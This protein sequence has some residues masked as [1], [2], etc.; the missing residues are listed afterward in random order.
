[1]NDLTELIRNRLD[2]LDVPPPDLAL[3][4]RRGHRL[5]GLRAVAAASAVVVA[6]VAVGLLVDRTGGGGADDGSRGVDPIGRL[7]L[8]HGLRA[9]AAP[10]AEIHLG[11]RTFPAERLEFLDTDATATSAGVLFYD[12]GVPHLLT[13]SGEITDLEPDAS[14]T[15]VRTTSK[16]DSVG[17]VV[18]YGA[19]L[20]GQLEVRVRDLASGELLASHAV[21]TDTVIDAVDDGVVFLRGDQGTT[22]W[23]T[24]TDEQRLFAGPRT[25]VADVR[26]GVVLYDGPAP[27]G[28]DAGA[29]RLVA[30]GVDAQLTYDGEHVLYWSSRLEPTKPG[31]RPVLLDAGSTAPGPTS[32]WW[33][34]DTDGSILAAVPGRDQTSTVYDCQVPSGACAE[35]GPLTTEHGDP[36]FIGVD[37]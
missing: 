4:R 12:R 30:G 19:E 31:G 1:M 25:T 29:Y 26:N 17:S 34:V 11:G 3:V 36:M 9:Y 21:P 20:D 10:D 2:A 37:M 6:V 15:A 23:D 7:D 24:R 13:E 28:P 22:R 5:R 8:S 18:A 32:G 33:A 14:R 35:L 16:V 27:D